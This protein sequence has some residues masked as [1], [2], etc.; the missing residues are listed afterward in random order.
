MPCSVLFLWD[1]CLAE[2]AIGGAVL[3]LCNALHLCLH[4]N[5]LHHLPA[6]TDVCLTPTAVPGGCLTG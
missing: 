1:G 6:Q 4:S 3:G 5:E 2:C